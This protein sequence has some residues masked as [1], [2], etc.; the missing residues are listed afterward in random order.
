[1]RVADYFHRS[2]QIILM[3]MAESVKPH[4]SQDFPCWSKNMGRLQWNCYN[5]S[6]LCALL[7]YG[8]IFFS[9][10]FPSFPLRFL[11]DYY[12]RSVY[13]FTVFICNAMSYWFSV[14][15]SIRMF[16]VNEVQND[17]V[18]EVPIKG[19]IS[20]NAILFGLRRFAAACG[21]MYFRVGDCEMLETLPNEESCYVRCHC[22]NTCDGN[23]DRERGWRWVK[24]GRVSNEYCLKILDA[25]FDS[26]NQV[27]P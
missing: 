7:F 2:S 17:F 22:N 11:W 19:N 25:L 1:M 6:V 5:F 13:F 24:V 26:K 18:L 4:S 21:A 14:V 23:F 3:Q 8:S 27:L 16:T 15:D 9:C 20:C 12:L 10:F